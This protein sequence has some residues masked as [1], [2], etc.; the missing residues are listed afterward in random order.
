MIN[1]SKIMTAACKP[2]GN[3][4]ESLWRRFGLLAMMLAWLTSLAFCP[5]TEA[6]ANFN[7]PAAK[8]ASFVNQTL[9]GHHF[10]KNANADGCCTG[11]Q[12]LSAV[13][14]PSDFGIAA[15]AILQAV[16]AVAVL[17]TALPA[18]TSKP[19]FT[20]NPLRCPRRFSVLGASWPHAP[21]H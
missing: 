21:P 12:H 14:R 13:D 19:R 16:L 18:A 6:I 7:A 20:Q 3:T 10:H 1:C 5:Q 11:Q 15:V 8:A 2:S 17:F 9:A 4:R